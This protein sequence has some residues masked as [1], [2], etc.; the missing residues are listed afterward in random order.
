MYLLNKL[1]YSFLVLFGVVTIVFLLFNVLPAD[2]AKMMLGDRDNDTQLLSINQK[3][4]FDKPLLVQ[5]AYYIND[6]SPVSIRYNDDVTYNYLNL[7]KFSSFEIILKKPYLRQSFY[8]KNVN[9]SNLIF[10][11]LP[12]T[13]VLAIS[14]I[15]FAIL[16]GIPF[17]CISAIYKDKFID[18]FITSFSV[19]GMS[20][21][22][23]FSAI[24][25]VYLF[26]Y[27]LGSLTGL[28]ITGSLFIIDDFGRGSV[29]SARNLI[30]PTLTL[31]IRPLSVIVNL[32]RA[33]L[34]DVLSSDYILLA[35]SKGL[36]NIYILCFHALPNAMSSVVTAT[37]GWFAGMLS[38]AVF[39]E[40]IFG[41]NGLGKLLVDGLVHVDFP[42]VMGVILVISTCF[43]IINILVDLIYIWLDP[44][45]KIN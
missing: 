30:L 9:V 11:A 16:F 6:L 23:F 22:S 13:F 39:V 35:K 41:W 27:Q 18:H 19:L 40:Y 20:L 4:H 36:S 25:I 34:L 43:I 31:A 21:P 15:F 32:T 14:S 5:Y 17:G 37:S 2:P 7:I 3:Y 10:S 1:A 33:S 45:V 42:V 38:G 24:L 44:R 29:L 26:A 8:Q 12:N 28:N